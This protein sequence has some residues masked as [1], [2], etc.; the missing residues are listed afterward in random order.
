M[1]YFRGGGGLQ[2]WAGYLE[3]DRGI[4]SGWTGQGEFDIYFC[5]LLDC[6]CQSLIYGGETGR[7][8]MSP[9][10]FE[11]FPIFPYFLRS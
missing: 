2:S 9:T 5:V 7:L 6:Y 3:R 11:T 8:T 10:K 1:Y 4:R